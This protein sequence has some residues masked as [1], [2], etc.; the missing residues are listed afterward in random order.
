MSGSSAVYYHYIYKIKKA[1]TS[2]N[3]LDVEEMFFFTATLRDEFSDS[4]A[5]AL[6]K[7]CLACMPLGQWNINR[8]LM[9][10]VF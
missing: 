6:D 4:R 9:Q 10:S 7:A 8:F 2:T 1:Q 3:I 5:F